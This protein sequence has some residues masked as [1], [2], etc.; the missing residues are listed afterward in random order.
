MVR[1]FEQKVKYSSRTFNLH[2]FLNEND[3]GNKLLI[4]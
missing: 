4:N 1:N 3:D 2:E